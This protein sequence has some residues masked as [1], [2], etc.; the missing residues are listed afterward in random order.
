MMK[1]VA[2]ATSLLFTGGLLLTGIAGAADGQQENGK[3][4]AA[5][6]EKQELKPQTV[7][8]VMGGKV[9]KDLYVDAQG[10]RI[11]VCCGGCIGAVKKDPAKY[12]EKL[13]QQGVKVAKLAE[14]KEKPKQCPA[15]KACTGC[16]KSRPKKGHAG[17]HHK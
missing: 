17:H 1:H 10:K 13:H 4:S 6:E 3:K 12:I 8:P 2:I 14:D 9:N 7:C 5:A 15:A 11:Y 16:V